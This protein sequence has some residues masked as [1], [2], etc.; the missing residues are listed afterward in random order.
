[1]IEPLKIPQLS[2]LQVLTWIFG[3]FF[4]PIL[5][6]SSP[7][8]GQ[9]DLP[10]L[11]KKAE[12][13]IVV[14]LTYNQAGKQI[15]QGTGFFINRSGDVITN[16]HVLQRASRSEIRLSNGQ[17]YPVK[18]V[19]AE[20]SDGDL[21]RLSVLIPEEK[22]IPLA[23]S[24]TLP[25]VGEKVVVIGNPLGLDQTV[26]DGIVSAIREVPGFGKIVQMTA[27]ISPGS[28]GSPVLDMKGEVIGVATFLILAGQNLNFAI[29]GERISKMS[30][31][32]GR[33]LAEREERRKEGQLEE[34]TEL[35]ATGLRYVWAGKCELALPYFI[36]AAKR[37]PNHGRAFFHLGYCLVQMGKNR[38]ALGPYERALKLRPQ[39]PLIHNNLCGVYGKLGHYGEAVEACKQAIQLKPDLPEA[40]N[41]LAWS[42]HQQGR[43]Q[44]AI[45]SSRQAIRLQPDMA[46]AH[47]NLGNGYAAQK[48]YE[49]AAEAYKQAIRL[50]FDYAEAHL[51]LGA[52]YNQMGRY[53]EAIGSYKRA[54]RL[55]PLM[56]EGHLNL[57]M[58]YLKWGDKGSA[59]EEY[60]ILKDL[61]KEMAN[62]LFNLIYE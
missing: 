22:V 40:H 19:I 41:N 4:P 28:S 52:A 59:I 61:N 45:E 55:K 30:I 16:H 46:T 17:K 14:I 13:S 60:K 12:P 54:L 35:Y 2:S 62:Q 43:Y 37:N 5:W 39:D 56:A 6:I 42:Y 1:M 18:G 50:E 31:G 44:E 53:E 27:P 26:S 57:G 7:A 36:E 32:E 10:S 24:P 47:Y 25:Q 51:N 34:A 3:V 49:E 58:T 15:G 11:I 9:A 38:E 8:L 33:N 20:D 23:I 48:R 29:P 21:V